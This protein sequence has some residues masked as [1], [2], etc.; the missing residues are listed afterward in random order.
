MPQTLR[1][2]TCLQHQCRETCGTID[3][4]CFSGL[5]TWHM[6]SYID[7][8]PVSQLTSC[9][10]IA[11]CMHTVQCMR[12][13]HVAHVIVHDHRSAWWLPLG[14]LCLSVGPGAS[15][16][17]PPDCVLVCVAGGRSE[18][19][20]AWCCGVCYGKNTH[21]ACVLRTAHTRTVVCY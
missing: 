5:D 9:E 12:D 3:F 19:A 10:T 16:L 8:S 21:N 20:P 1:R 4:V 18:C 15:G 2:L 17:M 14:P 11:G 7:V 6:M 13:A